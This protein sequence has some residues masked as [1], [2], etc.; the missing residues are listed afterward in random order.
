MAGPLTCLWADLLNQDAT[1]TPENI[2]LLLQRVLV[3]LGSASYNV[4]QERRRVALSQVNPTIN[5]LPDDTEEA[6]EKDKTL[7]GGGFLK[8][9]TK[10]IE[11]E[12]VLAKVAG[13]GH[14]PPP[15]KRHRLDNKKIQT[16]CAVFWRRVPLQDTVAGILGANSRIPR[17]DQPNSRRRATTTSSGQ[18]AS[19]HTNLHMLNS[20]LLPIPGIACFP[21]AGWLPCCFQNWQ[22]IM[23]DQWVFITNGLGIQVGAADNPSPEVTSMTSG[24][25]ESSPDKRGGAKANDQRCS[26]EGQP[27]CRSVPQSDIPSPEEGWSYRPVANLKPL[28]QFMQQVHFK[29][30]NLAMM[31]DL[32][33]ESD[34]MASIDLKDAYLSVQIWKDHRRYLWF[35]WQDSIYEFQCLP[36]GL[37]STP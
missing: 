13:A 4:T 15:V 23:A 34:W 27:M 17:K 8:K 2:I 21:T 10:R 16:T 20:V 30:E 28:N 11:E 35:L 36:F 29:M 7:F 32:L 22:K 3:L 25:W 5:S 26:K 14:K 6:K 37:S 33:R 12:K 24:G 18:K 1:V 9:A 19:T 31:R